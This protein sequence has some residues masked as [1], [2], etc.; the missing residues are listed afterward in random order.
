[1]IVIVASRLNHMKVLYERS[2]QIRQPCKTTSV[3][4]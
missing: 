2:I 3:Y 4:V 1:M